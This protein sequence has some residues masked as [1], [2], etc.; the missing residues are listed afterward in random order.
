MWCVHDTKTEMMEC[1]DKKDQCVWPNQITDNTHV[2]VYLQYNT[3][4]CIITCMWTTCIYMYIYV[5]VYDTCVY[6]IILLCKYLSISLPLQQM[7]NVFEVL[8]ANIY[9]IKYMCMYIWHI[10][11]TYMYTLYMYMYMTVWY[12]YMYMYMKSCTITWQTYVTSNSVM[13]TGTF[14]NNGGLLPK[15]EKRLIKI[16]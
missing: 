3:R 13:I 4:P 14:V 2:H 9:N 5:H 11:G 15:T 8:D 1:M 12:M 7:V 10:H 16:I 6:C